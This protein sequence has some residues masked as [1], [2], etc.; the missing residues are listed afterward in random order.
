MTTRH[1]FGSATFNGRLHAADGWVRPRYQSISSG[2]TVTAGGVCLVDTSGGAFTV[3]VSVNF[4]THREPV[5]FLD[6]N[7]SCG[8][9]ALTVT[10]GS[11]SINST[12]T[13]GITATHGTIQLWS[14]GTN[15]IAF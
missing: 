7:G 3:T 8:A 15:F 10:C 4:H 14:N 13:T 9:N 6:S 11:G 2:T 12:A 5:L 1:S